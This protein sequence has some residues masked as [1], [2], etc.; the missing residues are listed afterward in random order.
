[1][2][3]C[4]SKLYVQ[5]GIISNS[6]TKPMLYISFC[7]WVLTK[8]FF[9]SER[10][11]IYKCWQNDESAQRNTSS[12]YH[13][14]LSGT[15]CRKSYEQKE[16]KQNKNNMKKKTF[17]VRTGSNLIGIPLFLCTAPEIVNLASD[18]IGSFSVVLSMSFRE[19]IDRRECGQKMRN[20]RNSRNSVNQ[21]N[22]GMYIAHTASFINA[23]DVNYVEIQLK[24]ASNDLSIN[25]KCALHKRGQNCKMNW[26]TK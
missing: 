12:V 21:C 20:S 23:I 3:L 14:W 17:V 7:F 16:W 8:F 25:G 10:F 19:M 2:S 15:L 11:I 26:I 24:L 18:V 13:G 5:K 1:M 6:S 4:Y 9:N 22:N